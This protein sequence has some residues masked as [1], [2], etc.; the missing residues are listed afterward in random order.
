[1]PALRLSGH[2]AASGMYTWTHGHMGTWMQGLAACSAVLGAR[3]VC[4]A[5]TATLYGTYCRS[6][7]LLFTAT[8]FKN[9][10]EASITIESEQAR[11]AALGTLLC[12]PVPARRRDG[13]GGAE[14]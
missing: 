2:R 11:Y 4:N 3:P 14:R 9:T 1:M 5:N 10:E 7:R 13:A 12:I 8:R 6:V